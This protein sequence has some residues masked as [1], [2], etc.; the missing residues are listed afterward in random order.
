MSKWEKLLQK[1]LS[2]SKDMRFD[3][4]R[5]VLESHGYEMNAPRSGSSHYTFRKAGYQPITI[6]K[7]EPIKKVYVQMVK[8][9]VESEVQKHEND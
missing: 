4:L 7:H 5:R 3:E 6:P 2:L 9:I 8:E 1:I